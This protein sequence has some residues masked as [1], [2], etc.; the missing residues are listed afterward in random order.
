MSSENLVAVR[1]ALSMLGRKTTEP[2]ASAVI[3]TAATRTALEF[4]VSNT[5][6]SLNEKQV[7]LRGIAEGLFNWNGTPKTTKLVIRALNDALNTPGKY[8]HA[9]ELSAFLSAMSPLLEP[10]RIA[11]LYSSI[12]E[13]DTVFAPAKYTLQLSAR[14]RKVFAEFPQERIEKLAYDLWVVSHKGRWWDITSGTAQAPNLPPEP[15][16]AGLNNNQLVDMFLKGNLPYTQLNAERFRKVKPNEL[17]VEALEKYNNDFLDEKMIDPDM[18]LYSSY[19]PWL[20]IN[21]RP[22]SPIASL[23]DNLLTIVELLDFKHPEKPK[24]F[25]EL[26]PD[27]KLYGKVGFPFDEH[28]LQ[29]EGKMLLPG[30]RMEIV[31]NATA[32]SENRDY[33]GNCTWSYKSGMEKGTYVLYRIHQGETIYN[34]ALMLTK[35]RWSVREINSRH[36]RGNVP[37]NIKNAFDAFAKSLPESKQAIENKLRSDYERRL[38][39]HK[40]AYTLQN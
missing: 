12:N 2:T 23:I 26:F 20:E 6:E 15:E 13:V 40:Y 18:A 9:V 3:P 36:N 37:A 28:I 5:A 14:L 4:L 33:M 30:V 25:R 31:M 11:R 24:N 38:K 17:I 10:D 22:E 39:N 21:Q 7:N 16:E 32:L 19:L 27:V 35:N 29:T 34:G 8:H 1:N